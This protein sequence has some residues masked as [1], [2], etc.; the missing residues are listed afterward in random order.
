MKNWQFALT[1]PLPYPECQ[2]LKPPL[3]GEKL[4][5]WLK[6]YEWKACPSHIIYVAGLKTA[7]GS[8]LYVTRPCLLRRSQTSSY[9]LAKFP[10]PRPCPHFSRISRCGKQVGKNLKAQFWDRSIRS[11]TNINSCSGLSVWILLITYW[12]TTCLLF[13]CDIKKPSA[14][15][16]TTC[17]PGMPSILL[18]KKRRHCMYP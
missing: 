5:H 14:S 12:N 9:F 13:L 2:C 10:K 3:F 4:M 8:G 16:N 15:H 11:E 6:R 7:V 1:R 17:L 18:F